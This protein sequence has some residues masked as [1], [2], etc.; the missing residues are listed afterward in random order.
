M[1][2]CCQE[3]CLMS[4]GLIETNNLLGF[5]L[6]TSNKSTNCEVCRIR[7]FVFFFVNSV[8]CNIL[9]SLFIS[10]F[11]PVLHSNC[12]SQHNHFCYMVKPHGQ[13]VLVSST[14]YNASTPSLSTS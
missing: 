4:L 2:Y 12:F 7:C 14:P 5:C 6:S 13:L 10:H 8:F 11:Y 3:N 1:L 9:D